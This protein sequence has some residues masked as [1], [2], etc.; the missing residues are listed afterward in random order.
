VLKNQLRRIQIMAGMFYS[1]KEVAEKLNKTEEEIKQIVQQGKLREFRDGPNLLFKVDE[2]EALMSDTDI[3]SPKEPSAAPKEQ[4]GEADEIVLAPEPPETAPEEKAGLT[5]ADTV[6]AAGGT[7]VLGETGAAGKTAGDTAGQAGPDETFL[8]SSDETSVDSS[9]KESLEK[10]EEDV[11]LDSFGSGSG[12]LDL[13]LQ[14]DDTSLG[15][16]LDEIYAPE[17]EEQQQAPA[18]AE[19]ASAM[20]LAAETEQM[21]SDQPFDASQPSVVQTPAAVAYPESKPDVLSNAFGIMLFLPLLAVFYTAVVA[22][23]GFSG[24]SPAILEKVQGI[25]WYVVIGLVVVAGLVISV[26]F[27]LTSSA[28]KAAA[29]PKEKKKKEPKA[30]K[31]KKPKKEKK[32][33]KEKEPKA[34]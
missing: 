6:V 9:A 34:Q 30:K 8:V 33:K 16:I 32:S 27:M 17:G 10:I 15:G 25:I 20:D 4:A 24:T 19:P 26:A 18:A 7:D 29:K 21:L 12:L 14:A 3:M 22:V 13:S 28:G 2:V 1:L 5:D 23:A 11:S 31:E